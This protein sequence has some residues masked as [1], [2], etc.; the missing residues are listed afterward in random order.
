MNL[1]RLI[2]LCSLH[3]S[4]WSIECVIQS[5]HNSSTVKLLLPSACHQIHPS[6]RSVIQAA[7]L[8]VGMDSLFPASPY[9][10]WNTRMWTW[11][12]TE[13]LLCGRHL[14]NPPSSSLKLVTPISMCVCV[15]N[16]WWIT[17]S[18][19]RSHQW[20]AWGRWDRELG[21]RCRRNRGISW[22]WSCC[23]L[24]TGQGGLCGRVQFCQ[25]WMEKSHLLPDESEQ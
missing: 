11:K 1:Y 6:T 24:H 13:V 5:I 19:F 4:W 3:Y 23:P 7:A 14:Q 8:P 22:D 17:S 2:V 21:S 15:Q 10:E 9:P 20:A 25:R 16:K 12:A 18:L